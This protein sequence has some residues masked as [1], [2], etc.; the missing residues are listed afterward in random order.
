MQIKVN[1]KIFKDIEKNLSKIAEK[2]LSNKDLLGS[3]GETI[4]TDIQFQTRKG[5]SI[6]LK[7]AFKPVGPAWANARQVLAKIN[8]THPAARLSGRKSTLNFTGRF[9]DSLGFKTSKAKLNFEFEGLHQGY[10]RKNG[11]RSKKVKNSDIAKGLAE[12]GRPMLGL[13]EQIK[14]RAEREVIAYLR[15][16]L[17]VYNARFK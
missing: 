5:Y 1:T 7:S 13:R 4:K 14:K 11:K 9:L 6:P 16:G 15:R 10:L 12:Q 8:P 2:V 3:I 17:K